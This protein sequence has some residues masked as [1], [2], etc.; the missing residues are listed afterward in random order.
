MTRLARRPT[1][2][3]LRLKAHDLLTAANRET[4][5]DGYRRLREAFER[6]SG[7]RIVTNLETGGVESTRGFGLIAHMQGQ[8]RLRVD[9]VVVVEPGVIDPTERI[10][11]DERTWD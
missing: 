2:P 5:G 11:R 7:A 6:L 9:E 10:V 3:T 1:S 4:S 8:A